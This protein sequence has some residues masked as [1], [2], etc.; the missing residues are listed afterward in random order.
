VAVHLED[1]PPEGGPLGDE[2][3]RDL[4]RDAPVRPVAGPAVLL[5]PVVVDDDDEIVEGVARRGHRRLPDLTLLALAVA[6]HHVGPDVVAREACAQGHAHAGRDAH[7]QRPGGHVQ[8][9]QAGHVGM[10][11]EPGVRGV[12]GG[13]LLDREVAP[14]RHRGIQ[15][16]R[17]M[18]LAEDEPV[19]VRPGRLVGADAH[20]VEVEGGQHVGGGEGTAEMAGSCVVDGLDDL[21]PDLPRDLL[22]TRDLVGV[23]AGDRRLGHDWPFFSYEPGTTG[24][25]KKQTSSSGSGP[26]DSVAWNVPTETQ[27]VTPDSISAVASG[28]TIRPR[29]AAQ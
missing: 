23:D 2:L 13:Q 3:A 5:K 20:D 12:E 26:S 16:D 9:G 14:Q 1:A 6:E 21:E 25:E 18:A 27:T 24:G 4:R 19:A 28:V 29:P 15:A 22:E 10:A 8:P 17:R 11:L 7:A